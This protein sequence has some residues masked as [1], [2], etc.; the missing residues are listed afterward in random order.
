MS[1]HRVVLMTWPTSIAVDR[2]LGH[3]KAA[4][5]QYMPKNGCRRPV[6]LGGLKGTSDY[7]SI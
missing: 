1:A 7:I 2:T 6:F 5:Q 4:N 3:L